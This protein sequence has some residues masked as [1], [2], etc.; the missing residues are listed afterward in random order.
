MSS[1]YGSTPYRPRPPPPPVMRNQLS[2]PTERGM[3][4]F[5][6]AE[7]MEATAN[8]NVIRIQRALA[9]MAVLV[10]R[11]RTRDARAALL[12][13]ET[14]LYDAQHAWVDSLVQLS[15]AG[16]GIRV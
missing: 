5:R 10:R 7:G 4:V 9:E 3:A 11:N 1:F 13:M 15:D 8:N 6:R 16:N 14:M 2:R 12:E